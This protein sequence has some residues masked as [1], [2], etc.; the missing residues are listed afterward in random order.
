VSIISFSCFPFRV[1]DSCRTVKRISLCVCTTDA[2]DVRALSHPTL[3]S[4]SL[5]AWQLIDTRFRA[6][7]RKR[8]GGLRSLLL[9]SENRFVFDELLPELIG[10]C[11]DSLTS[12]DLHFPR[13]CEVQSSILFRTESSIL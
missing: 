3:E 7:I 12:L 13:E 5:H 4:L 2:T 10:S 11:S 9:H 6:W 8:T 1:L